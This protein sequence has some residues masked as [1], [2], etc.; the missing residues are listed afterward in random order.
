MADDLDVALGQAMQV[1]AAGEVGKG[2]RTLIDFLAARAPDD[3]TWKRLRAFDFDRD[4]KKIQASLET[5]LPA[6]S[7]D[8]FSHFYFGLDSLNMS[9]GKGIEFGCGNS[10]ENYTHYPGNIPSGGLKLIFASCE[11]RI[12]HYALG[13]GFLGLA[14]HQAFAQLAPELAKG[15][16]WRIE[17]GFHD[18]DLFPLGTASKGGIRLELPPE[19]LVPIAQIP[20]K[21]D[22]LAGIWPLRG[23]NAGDWYL[24]AARAASHIDDPAE[25]SPALCGHITKLCENARV[26]D[27]RLFLPEILA[28]I[29]KLAEPR[30]RV[31]AY[32]C[33]AKVHAARNENDDALAH[34]LEAR[35]IAGE[36]S[37]EYWRT[38][39]QSEV[40]YCARDTGLARK[41]GPLT[42]EQTEALDL[43]EALDRIK[44][45]MHTNNPAQLEVALRNLDEV[46]A[47]APLLSASNY[48]TLKKLFSAIGDEARSRSLEATPKD[49]NDTLFDLMKD[50]P[51]AEG[52]SERP[53]AYAARILDDIENEEILRSTGNYHHLMSQ[54]EMA[55]T[56]V[57]R[58]G[59]PHELQHLLVRARGIINS[60]SMKSG[61]FI[62]AAVHYTLAE[63]LGK[64]GL[65][66]EARE[67]LDLAIGCAKR[68]R[69]AST[70]A[71]AFRSLAKTCAKLREWERALACAKQLRDPD[72]KRLATAIV[73]KEA[74]R[75]EEL[76]ALLCNVKDAGKASELA[77]QVAWTYQS[78]S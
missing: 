29:P 6:A 74:D 44:S 60:W 50:L 28:G 17:F 9:D 51:P 32:L 12:A 76:L 45:A 10:A 2:M 25:K 13:I 54:I 62:A 35:L 8:A 14:L 36:I 21:G 16:E 63:L 34:L 72:E 3:P 37:N 41:I 27:A 64:A 56:P 26:D 11:D 59:D 7:C 77:M 78:R 58:G 53:A 39:A 46:L 23:A 31:E 30:D 67:R 18:G 40:Y 73:L 61:G 43:S 57:L 68:E 66:D 70:R 47:V 20:L 55:L 1:I 52:S 75:W 33:A 69:T 24:A 22:E 5:T 65:L 49:Q 4:A 19:F 42:A 15:A 38:N 48:W 71:S